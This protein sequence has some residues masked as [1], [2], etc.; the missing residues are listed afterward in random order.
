M[1]HQLAEEIQRWHKN[2][3]PQSTHVFAK[4]TCTPPR[5]M[6]MQNCAIE[7]HK[8]QAT[9]IKKQLLD[10]H[11]PHTSH[12]TTKMN[13]KHVRHSPCCVQHFA[14]TRAS[15]PP[16]HIYIPRMCQTWTDSKCA[17]SYFLTHTLI[18]TQCKST[19]PLR[20]MVERITCPCCTRSMKLK[21]QTND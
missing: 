9:Q 2:I 8:K 4:M 18:G 15:E 7:Q 20:N 21:K 10:K 17:T 12:R 3:A 11:Q 6:N 1:M 19:T 14:R 5:K 13:S 16:L